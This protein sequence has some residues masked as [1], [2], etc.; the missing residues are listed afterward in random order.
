MNSRDGLNALNL[1]TYYVEVEINEDLDSIIKLSHK[2]ILDENGDVIHVKNLTK[3]T[4][5][6]LN[7][8]YTV[9]VDRR[10]VTVLEQD[11]GDVIEVKYNRYFEVTFSSIPEE[12]LSGDP[13]SNRIRKVEIVLHTLSESK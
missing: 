11:P 2:A 9:A 10:S 7:T 5:L 1:K 6:N 4:T 3:G 8:D 12:W 13:E